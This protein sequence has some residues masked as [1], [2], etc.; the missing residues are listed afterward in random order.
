MAQSAIYVVNNSA[1]NVAVNGII[2]PGTII[3]R[4]GRNLN[5]SGNAV[6]VA[7]EGYY[8]FDVSITLAPTAAGNVTVTA[9]KDGVAIPGMIASETVAAANDLVNLSLV[10]LVREGCCCCDNL[11]AI[12]FVLSGTAASVTNIAIVGEKI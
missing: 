10:G 3:R 8:D 11:S 5:L 6:Q 9:F 1:Q 12:T 4:Y 2:N 7:G